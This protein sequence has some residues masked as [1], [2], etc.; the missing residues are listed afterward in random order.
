MDAINKYNLPVPSAGVK[1][2]MGPTGCP[3]TSVINYR[4]GVITQKSSVHKVMAESDCFGAKA[5]IILKVVL[6]TDTL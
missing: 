6:G 5:K 4:S 1:K 2:M 3:E